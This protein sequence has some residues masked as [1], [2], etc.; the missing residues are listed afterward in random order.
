MFLTG[1]AAEVVPVREIDDHVIGSGGTAGEAGGPGPIT[2]ELQ[3]IYDDAIHG[4]DPR[5]TGWLDLV[6]IPSGQPAGA[7]ESV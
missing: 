2:R 5:Y 3:R 7:A 4:R 1:T 6:E